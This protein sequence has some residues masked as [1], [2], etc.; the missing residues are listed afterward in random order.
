MPCSEVL[1][2]F[3]NAVCRARVPEV[4]R[5][6]VERHCPYTSQVVA[7]EETSTRIRTQVVPAHGLVR[8]GPNGAEHGAKRRW[9]TRC[10]SCRVSAK[11]AG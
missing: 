11:R 1:E 4:C 6:L 5:H 7:F 9:P 2:K 3:K 8:R 10:D